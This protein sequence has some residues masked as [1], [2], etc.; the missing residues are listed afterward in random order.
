VCVCVYQ[1][2]EMMKKSVVWSFYTNIIVSIM[3]IIVYEV[4]G[5]DFRFTSMLPLVLVLPLSLSIEDAAQE[6]QQYSR[7]V[8]V[9]HGCLLCG[10]AY[11]YMACISKLSSCVQSAGVHTFCLILG[12]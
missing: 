12:L 1:L 6:M 7:L 5:E 8:G 2:G 3:V 4:Y 11:I 9:A 10:V